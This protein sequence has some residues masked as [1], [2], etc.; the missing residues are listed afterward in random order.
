VNI[1]SGTG[2]TGSVNI[3]TGTG[4]GSVTIGG[5]GTAIAIGNSTGTGTITMGRPLTL[6]YNPSALTGTTQLG[7]RIGGATTGVTNLTPAGNQLSVWSATLTS[8]IWLIQTVIRFV[9]PGAGATQYIT[10]SIS[11][12]NNSGDIA[13]M[14]SIS[15]TSTTNQVMQTTRIVNT[16]TSGLGPW[17]LVAQCSAVTNVDSIV[18][19]AYRIA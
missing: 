10:A 9:T 2:S 16:S 14:I 15:N 6:N 8:G 19:N 5:T 12:T 11:S 13:A 3:K 1:L 4:S 7:Y 18:F 17:Y